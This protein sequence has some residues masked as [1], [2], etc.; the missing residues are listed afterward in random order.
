MVQA[1]WPYEDLHA[2]GS[3]LVHGDDDGR[4][5]P[6]VDRLACRALQVPELEDIHASGVCHTQGD[7]CVVAA[8]RSR[9]VS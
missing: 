2:Q 8:L 7:M 5:G 4:P 1:A 3:S 9:A 6:C